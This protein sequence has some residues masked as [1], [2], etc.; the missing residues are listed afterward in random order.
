[1]ATTVA[2]TSPVNSAVMNSPT[3]FEFGNSWVGGGWSGSAPMPGVNI[4][5][6][7]TSASQVARIAFTTDLVGPAFAG[8]LLSALL[9]FTYTVSNPCALQLGVGG[10]SVGTG[11]GTVTADI[12]SALGPNDFFASGYSDFTNSPVEYNNSPNANGSIAVSLARYELTLY[13]IHFGTISPVNGDPAGGTTVTITLVDVDGTGADLTAAVHAVDFGLGNPADTGTKVRLN[14]T[15]FTIVVPPQP[16]TDRAG[17]T[18]VDVILNSTAAGFPASAAIRL[19]LG[20]TYGVGG[21][22]SLSPS[23]DAGS[24]G[25]TVTFTQE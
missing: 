20:F 5:G 4:L 18:L 12:T 6:S 15:Q 16:V 21:G 1:M 14:N 19:T 17:S 25:I 23:S 10:I 7:G 24:G 13:Q 3:T 8:Y 9:R 2:L 11:S 22:G